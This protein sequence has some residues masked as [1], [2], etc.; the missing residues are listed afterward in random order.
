MSEYEYEYDDTVYMDQTDKVPK[1]AAFSLLFEDGVVGKP[2]LNEELT[3]IDG[4]ASNKPTHVPISSV[5]VTEVGE[6]KIQFTVEIAN[7][8]V[9]VGAA[10]DDAVKV[11]HSPEIPY[12]HYII[13]TK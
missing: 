12:K 11:A 13:T 10:R 9:T 1:D 8:T 7:R 6:N 4:Q 2:S 3:L 5:S